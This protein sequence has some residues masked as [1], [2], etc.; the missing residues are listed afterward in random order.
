MVSNLLDNDFSNQ[1]SLPLW[2][3]KRRQKFSNY[4][5]GREGVFWN[6]NIFEKLGKTKMLTELSFM[7]WNSQYIDGRNISLTPHLKLTKSTMQP[8]IAMLRHKALHQYSG[9][10]NLATIKLNQM[11]LACQ[12]YLWTLELRYHHKSWFITLHY[13]VILM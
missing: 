5:R 4:A 10:S 1:S 7:L 9:S 6:T 12:T 2:N 3:Q 11:Y 8:A 13:T